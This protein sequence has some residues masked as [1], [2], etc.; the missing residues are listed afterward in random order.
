MN[1]LLVSLVMQSPNHL[2]LYS[3]VFFCIGLFGLLL[4][5]RLYFCSA[6]FSPPVE[7][8]GLFPPLKGPTKKERRTARLPLIEI[9]P[10]LSVSVQIIFIIMT[11]AVIVIVS[12]LVIFVSVTVGIP[13]G[14]RTA[15]AA[16]QNCKKYNQYYKNNKAFHKIHHLLSVMY[17]SVNAQLAF[18]NL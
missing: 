3:E 9:I 2:L 6:R 15:A 11:V 10:R 16:A 5:R 17:F 12:V 7:L 13:C 4:A 8:G 1:F 18:H 14:I